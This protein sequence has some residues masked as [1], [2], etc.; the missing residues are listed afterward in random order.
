ML[1]DKP[2]YALHNGNELHW[3]IECMGSNDYQEVK[4]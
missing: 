3:T 1:T 2:P 4:R